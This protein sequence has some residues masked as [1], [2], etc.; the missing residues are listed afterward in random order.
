MCSKNYT[1]KKTFLIY[2]K[3]QYGHLWLPEFYCICTVKLWQHTVSP[4]SQTCIQL[5]R[6][7][8]SNTEKNYKVGSD[9]G[10][11]DTNMIHSWIQ[12][13]TNVSIVVYYLFNYEYIVV[14]ISIHPTNEWI[15][16]VSISWIL[17]VSNYVSNY[18]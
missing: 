11:L 2:G 15:L 9:F 6:C 10:Y 3:I 13:T 7:A 17:L 1:V 12:S 5:F 18:T 16:I 8:L 4:K 14:S